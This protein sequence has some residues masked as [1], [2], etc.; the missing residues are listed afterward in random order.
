MFY[1]R[2]PLRGAT[3][4]VVKETAGWMRP[5][6]TLGTSTL[7]STRP[8]WRQSYIAISYGNNARVE[9]LDVTLDGPAGLRRRVLINSWI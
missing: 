9:S 4:E 3:S 7:A 1:K 5:G 6:L 8:S 2:K